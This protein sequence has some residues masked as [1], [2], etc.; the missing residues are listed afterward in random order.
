MLGP[1]INNFYAG[2]FLHVDDIRTLA[3]VLNALSVHEIV[4]FSKAFS[5]V[6]LSDTGIPIKAESE[7]LGY[8]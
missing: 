5:P 8:W 6:K 3:T 4:L 2:G 7:C 1:S